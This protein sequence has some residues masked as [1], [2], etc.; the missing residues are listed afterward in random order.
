[1]YTLFCNSLLCIA[2]H[3]SKQFCLKKKMQ[4]AVLVL[5]ALGEYTCLQC[6]YKTMK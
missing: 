4:V 2:L 5:I 3:L 6:Y 1:M